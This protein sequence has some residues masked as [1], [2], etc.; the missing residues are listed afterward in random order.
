MQGET[1]SGVMICNHCL[2][3]A[4]SLNPKKIEQ[5]LIA[6]K[7]EQEKAASVRKAVEDYIKKRQKN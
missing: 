6:S 3:N 1:Q 7:W 4:D 5:S 2:S